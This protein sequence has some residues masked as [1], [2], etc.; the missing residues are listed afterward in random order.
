VF[1]TLTLPNIP[2]TSQVI[3]PAFIP[4]PDVPHFT[5]N[6]LNDQDNI[7]IQENIAPLDV[8]VFP[9]QW[10]IRHAI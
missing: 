8:P 5:Q 3:T 6:N 10:E 4:V 7:T 2:S 9:E 1:P